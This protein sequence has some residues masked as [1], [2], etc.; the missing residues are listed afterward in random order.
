MQAGPTVTQHAILYRSGRDSRVNRA[1]I[2]TLKRVISK[3]TTPVSLEIYY[4]EPLKLLDWALPH[5][6]VR[7]VKLR[8]GE[9]FP[10]AERMSQQATD[11][12]LVFDDT[13]LISAADVWLLMG[14]SS[15]HAVTVLNAKRSVTNEREGLPGATFRE[16]RLALTGYLYPGGSFNRHA[17]ALNKPL[18]LS[19]RPLQRGSL[20]EKL[21]Y[22]ELLRSLANLK[23]HSQVA[24]SVAVRQAEEYPLLNA[25]VRT[26]EAFTSWKKDKVFPWW[27]SPRAPLFHVAQLAVYYGALVSLISPKSALIVF[28]FA[29]VITPQYFF[30]RL[31][32]RQWKLLPL[33]LL[34]RFAL[35]FVG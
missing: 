9:D 5:D 34:T 33:R 14:L 18:L 4:H 21:T 3:S 27:F 10:V 25:G 32:W 22:H 13:L 35:Y 19:K 12:L 16:A 1:N 31:K 28:L 11:R 2:S 7:Y 15:A 24:H 6:R 20:G 30:T 26:V 17:F 29:I 23:P 8:S